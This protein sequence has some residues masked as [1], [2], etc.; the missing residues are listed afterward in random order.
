MSTEKEVGIAVVPHCEFESCDLG[1][2]QYNCPL[3]NA[4]NMN[5]D[6]ELYHAAQTKSEIREV[7]CEECHKMFRIKY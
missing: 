7:E 6:L 1:T 4:F 5:F 3:C 2:L